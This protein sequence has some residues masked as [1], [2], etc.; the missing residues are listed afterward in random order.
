MDL[1][2]VTVICLC[3]NHERFVREAIFSVL[4]QTYENLELVIVDDASTDR[5][6]V[7]IQ[8]MVGGLPEIKFIQLKRNLG[9]CAAFNRGLALATG[10]YIVDFSTDDVMM[11]DRIEKQVNFFKTLDETYGVVFTD[12][13]YIDENSRPI[14]KHFDYLFTKKLINK[15][16]SGD[17]YADLL[18]T[19]YVSS[20]SMLVK[21]DVFDALQGYDET[22]AYEDF[23]FWIRSSRNFKYAFLNETLTKVRRVDH[24]LSRKAY[25][26]G[27]AQ[28][29]STYIVCRK[30]QALNRTEA[31]NKALVKRVRYELRH[32]V[33]SENY[34][35]A[36]LFL[37][38][39]KELTPLNS[40]DNLLTS[41]L[42]MRLPLARLRR[43]YHGLRYQ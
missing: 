30:A 42:K 17:V 2:L 9:N 21:R 4:E 10:E 40:W 26:K 5:S 14:Q 24:S 39:L 31:E 35:E 8:Q 27:D 38:L 28:L 29:H 18:Q 23:D 7:E 37:S 36:D 32:A 12:V 33:L 19:Y 22:L 11:P 1:P 16:P 43:L 34:E 15:I 25:T 6:T 13:L 20:P 3:Y 41:L